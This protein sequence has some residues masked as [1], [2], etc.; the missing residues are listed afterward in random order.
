GERVVQVPVGRGRGRR[1]GRPGRRRAGG[2]RSPGEEDGAPRQ[3]EEG[4]TTLQAQTNRRRA[5]VPTRRRSRIR[6]FLGAELW[7]TARRGTLYRPA[8]ILVRSK[9]VHAP[10]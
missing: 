8:G 3:E 10:L 9:R 1:Q 6:A 4:L 7:R 5:A 2:R